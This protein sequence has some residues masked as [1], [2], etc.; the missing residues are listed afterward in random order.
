MWVCVCGLCV[1]VLSQK[2]FSR[3][4]QWAG[5]QRAQAPDTWLSQAWP[6]CA[7]D[8]R[9]KGIELGVRRSVQQT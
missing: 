7:G 1:S 9:E 2:V 6:H 8:F 3:R 5:D 4:G